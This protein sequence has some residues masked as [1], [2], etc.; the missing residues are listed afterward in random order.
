MSV[1]DFNRKDVVSVVPDPLASVISDERRS[2]S[3]HFDY[4]L[5]ERWSAAVDSGVC[6]YKLNILRTAKLPGRYSFVLQ[7]PWPIEF[8]QY[9]VNFNWLDG[10][11]LKAE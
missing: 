9:R 1:F 6:C 8:D 3:S 10:V 5:R 11:Y 4:E 7:V 2:A